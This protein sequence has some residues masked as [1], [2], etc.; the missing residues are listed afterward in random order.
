[1]PSTTPTRL[2]IAAI[3]FLNPAPLLYDFEHD[4]QATNLRDRYS[5]HYTTPAQCAEQLSNGEADLG[6]VPIGALPHLP[7]LAAVPGCVIAS[8][9]QVRSIQ[10]VIKPGLALHNMRTVAADNASRSSVAYLQVILRAFYANDPGFTQSPA[11]LAPM[12]QTADAALLIGDPA[13]L[14][15]ENRDAYPGHT[16]YDL[17]SLWN[18]HTGLPWVAAVWAVNPGALTATTPTK[19]IED[20]TNSRDAGLTHIDTLVQDWQPRIAIPPETIRTYLTA[21]IHYDLDPACLQA[22]AEFY[23]LAAQTAVLPRYNLPLLAT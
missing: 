10:L 18:E 14:A 21:N 7:H 22:I 4:P 17:A 9:R 19:L 20:L 23:R 12:L 6:L 16:W 8:L 13:L 15:L 5:L 2:R 1:V 3:S 11:A